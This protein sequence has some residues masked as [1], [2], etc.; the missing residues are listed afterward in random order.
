MQGWL[1]ATVNAD[2]LAKCMN[3]AIGAHAPAWGT[4][5][6]T[7]VVHPASRHHL[8]LLKAEALIATA[9]PGKPAGGACLP[10]EQQQRFSCEGHHKAA[11]VDVQPLNGRALEH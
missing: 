5:V 11:A 8:G 3:M 2:A 4:T 10:V 6:K 1:P 7:T 9:L